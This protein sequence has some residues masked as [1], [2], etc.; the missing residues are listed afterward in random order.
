MI[1]ERAYQ[2]EQCA[3]GGGSFAPRAPLR[4]K[5]WIVALIIAVAVI[6]VGGYFSFSA[7]QE[8]YEARA[9]EEARG[10]EL[11]SHSP[12]KLHLPWQSHRRTA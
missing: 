3:R 11:H 10:A 7:W 4:V 6:G 9:S 12:R 1:H 8:A 2:P 5:P